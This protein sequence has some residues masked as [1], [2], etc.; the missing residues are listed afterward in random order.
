MVILDSDLV[1]KVLRGKPSTALELYNYL[2]L[3]DIPLKTTI[4]SY[5]ELI[6]GC[7]LS[8]NVPKNLEYVE[9]LLKN[10]TIVPFEQSDAKKFGQIQAYLRKNRTPI[11]DL[12]AAEHDGPRSTVFSRTWTI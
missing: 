8:K 12:D 4:F 9:S 11:G 3:H 5:G 7:F 1:I 6:E 10:F 2:V